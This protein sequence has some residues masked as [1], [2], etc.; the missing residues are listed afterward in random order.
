MCITLIG[1]TEA[2]VCSTYHK[3]NK[4]DEITIPIGKTIAN[5][6]NYIISED[7][8]L[9]PKGYIGE[10]CIGGDGL[11][12]G[13][14]NNKK[15]TQEKFI[16]LNSINE[17]VYKTG[18]LCR[19]NQNN[20]FEFW[21]R[22]DKQLKIRGYRVS[23][24]EIEKMI[25]Q[26][27]GIDNSVVVD[28]EDEIG[29]KALCAYYTSNINLTK[30]EI[31][32][33]LKKVLP[34]YMIPTIYI[35]IDKIPVNTSGKLDKYKLPNPKEYLSKTKK[36][37]KPSTET[38][39]KL[40]KYWKNILNM[41][42]VSIDTDIFELGAD[43]LSI[44]EFQA[45]SSNENWN[46]S[47]Q[48]IYTNPSI[49]E[50]A[51]KITEIQNN[52][53]LNFE[54]YKDI[55]IR[56]IELPKSDT[57]INNI[58][59]TGA[60]GF[61]GIHILKNLLQYPINNIYCLVRGNEEKFAQKRLKDLYE[62]YFSESIYNNNKIKVIYGDITKSC[63]G[64]SE[65][66]YN[67]LTKNIDTVIHTAAT[68]K[69]YGN[70]ETFKEINV[71]G[72]Q[73]IV[74][75]CKISKS[76]LHYMSTISVSGQTVIG[77]DNEYFTE[78]DFWIGQNYNDN[79]YIESKFEAEYLVLKNILEENLYAKIYRIGNLTGRYKDGVFQK[80][81]ESNAF[82]TKLKTIID[83]KKIPKD[84]ADIDIDF[85]PV[86]LTTNAILKV[87]FKDNSKQIIYHLFNN[88]T[89]NINQLIILLNKL[90]QNIDIITKNEFEEIKD[91]TAK[92]FLYDIYSIKS[93]QN[94]EILNNIT[95]KRLKE[96]NFKWNIIDEIYLGKIIQYMKKVNFI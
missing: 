92:T 40:E 11:S 75:F 15:L 63:L 93:K 80:N 84:I 64:L 89:L 23:L 51:N 43:S 44:I 55:N 86:D 20:E 66:L 9:L 38:E 37:I 90:G 12:K 25:N 69:H 88:E 26:Y 49:Q 73:N 27:P 29:K 77:K 72:T 76:K 78:N 17:I 19:I 48:D 41:D 57:K 33:Y 45:I 50:L 5:Y 59:L 53:T 7:N 47:P 24:V 71:I 94:I 83:L 95:Q 18:D 36:Y 91:K 4:D 61:L 3:C 2:T 32:E 56:N 67:D 1:P 42:S 52:N 65:S 30:K 62:F 14:I 68:V 60:T 46:I 54:N 39:I 22:K 81:I 10:L 70:K 87:I 31:K 82:Y 96:L 21:G 74:D 16:F 35:K 6:K 58:L 28:F 8:Q 85:T 34:S 79:V 13:Y